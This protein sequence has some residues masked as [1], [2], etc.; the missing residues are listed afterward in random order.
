MEEREKIVEKFY[1]SDSDDGEEKFEH[2]EE[3]KENKVDEPMEIEEENV[4][5]PALFS[6]QSILDEMKIDFSSIKDELIKSFTNPSRSNQFNQFEDQD[7]PELISQSDF[8]KIIDTLNTDEAP[9]TQTPSSQKQVPK[10]SD[11]EAST[12]VENFNQ[13]TENWGKDKCFDQLSDDETTQPKLGTQST[14]KM[15]F[16]NFQP[17]LSGGPNQLIDLSEGIPEH[18][19]VNDLVGRLLQHSAW[20]SSTKSPKVVEIRY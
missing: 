5:E 2:K 11:L 3:E 6:I 17:R 7:D 20:K 19:G 4:E 14:P 10:I 13:A 8:N 1:R 15:H 9:I 12:L 18:K 16:K